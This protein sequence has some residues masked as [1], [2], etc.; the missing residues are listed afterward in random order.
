[1]LWCHRS[2][3]CIPNE[4]ACRIG[5]TL[6]AA[7]APSPKGIPV[8][9]TAAAPPDLLS[10]RKA[11][12]PA[13]HETPAKRAETTAIPL[14]HVLPEEKNKSDFHSNGKGEK[15]GVILQ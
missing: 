11:G 5:K 2:E 1:M 9:A 10:E 8:K 3:R 13:A 7:S 14:V 4:A 6:L 12:A 15:E